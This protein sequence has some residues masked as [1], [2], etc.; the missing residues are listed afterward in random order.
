KE[1]IHLSITKALLFAAVILFSFS[2]P[3]F[4][5]DDQGQDTE[6]VDSTAAQASDDAQS[7]G[8]ADQGSSAL[9][10][11]DHG[12]E[13]FNTNCAACHKRYKRSTGPA[14]H[15]VTKIREMSWIYDWVHRSEEHTSE[16]QSRF[17][18][19]CRLLLEKKKER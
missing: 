6:A 8:D 3:V 14:L 4:A 16:L 18:L 12:K 11:A 1:I 17:D 19:V 15:G 2:Q 9:G 13:L 5:Q 7:A 10:D